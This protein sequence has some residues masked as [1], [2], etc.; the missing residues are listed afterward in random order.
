MAAKGRT[1]VRK[2]YRKRRHSA[3]A[4][5]NLFLASGIVHNPGSNQPDR[6]LRPLI[7]EGRWQVDILTRQRL[8]LPRPFPWDDLFFRSQTRRPCMSLIP[9]YLA[10]GS[11]DWIF[12]S[13]YSL[14]SANPAP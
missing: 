3:A 9:E 11:V 7:Y 2:E 12:N 8:A 13:N 6:F 4:T 1:K 5:G 14:T 10:A